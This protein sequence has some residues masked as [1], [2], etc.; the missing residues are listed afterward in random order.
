MELP[1][2]VTTPKKHPYLVS[3]MNTS[4]AD[5]MF[6]TYLPLH[7]TGNSSEIRFNNYLHSFLVFQTIIQLLKIAPSVC[8]TIV[9]ENEHRND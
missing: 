3:F 1:S 6:I 7:T 9:H 2:G 5:S 4:I 8:S